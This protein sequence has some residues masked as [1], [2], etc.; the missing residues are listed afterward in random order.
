M[1]AAQVVAS[2]IVL[3]GAV[4]LSRG[5]VRATS[6][7]YLGFPTTLTSIRLGLPS[8]YTAVRAQ[9]LARAALQDLK[10]AG[11][12]A[13]LTTRPP[14]SSGY[15]R[16]R[17]SAPNQPTSA[18]TDAPIEEVDPSFFEVL[19]IPFLAGQ[20]FAMDDTRSDIVVNQALVRA[21][22]L[23]THAVGSTVVVDD[24]TYTIIGV[25]KDARLTLFDVMWPTVFR[26]LTAP[27]TIVIRGDAPAI[28]VRV[29]QIIQVIDAN[30]S[31]RVSTQEAALRAATRSARVGANVAASLAGI[32]LLLTMTGLFGVFGFTVEERR[33][34]I[35]IRLALGAR[36][37]DVLRL[38]FGTARRALITG[39][40]IGLV[41]G[42]SGGMILRSFLYGLS[43]L[44]PV[45]YVQ[46]AVLL[47]AVTAA[48]TYGPARRA[49]GVDP[50]V[51]LR[52][53]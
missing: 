18:S 19:G 42:V 39:L 48:A 20:T 5:I 35:G 41:L 43:P 53:E 28:E 4:L 23:S 50:A 45:S 8:G 29:R 22:G 46:V 9:H 13:T 52:C 21:L 40:A 38:L 49:L 34:E 3:T 26:P 12:E 30:V 17:V 2:V 37:S 36:P 25:V 24:K 10:A 11:L 15:Y 32:A 14:L 7:E 51:T 27:S 44:D 6:Q 47:A 31:V 16:K 1:L 33:R